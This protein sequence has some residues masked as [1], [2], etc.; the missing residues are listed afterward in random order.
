MIVPF[1]VLAIFGLAFAHAKTVYLNDVEVQ[2]FVSRVYQTALRGPRYREFLFTQNGRNCL[3]VLAVTDTSRAAGS[4]QQQSML[5]SLA[6]TMQT[7]G[8]TT[9]T[10]NYTMYK[11]ASSRLTSIILPY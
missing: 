6:S 8:A 4:S 7:L 1:Y 3:K 11:C 9:Q 10:L 2:K 5:E